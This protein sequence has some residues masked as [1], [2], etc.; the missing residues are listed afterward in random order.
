MYIVLSTL[1]QVCSVVLPSILAFTTHM[2]REHKDS[3]QE[4]NKPFSCDICGQGFYFLSSR[5]SHQSKAHRQTTGPT[6]RLF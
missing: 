2:R 3:E 4:R 5:N 1:A 6:F